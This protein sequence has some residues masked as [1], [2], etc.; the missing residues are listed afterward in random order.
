MAIFISVLISDPSPEG[1]IANQEEGKITR[2]FFTVIRDPRGN[3][4]NALATS[5]V[6]L[7]S[8]TIM[9]SI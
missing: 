1:N 8:G 9:A 6:G 5:P 7:R 2:R 4:K 3:N